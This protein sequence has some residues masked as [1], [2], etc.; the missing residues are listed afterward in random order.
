MLSAADYDAD[1]VIVGAGSAGCV[2]AERLS[3][4]GRHS[5]IVIEAGGSDRRFWINVPLG[6]GRL[7]YDRRVNWMYE[8]ATDPG[9][10]GRRDY[11][12]R[13]RVMGGSS[14]INAMVY[15]RGQQ[16]DY[17]GWAAEGNPGWGWDDVAPVFAD[18]EDHGG[19]HAGAPRVAI[20]DV[21]EHAHPLSRRV[22]E[23]GET[24][25]LPFNPDFNGA[26]QEGTG[27]YRLSRCARGRRMSAARAF[28]RP[29][30][31][32]ANVRVLSGVQVERV[33]F[34]GQRAT[35][36]IARDAGRAGR[37]GATVTIRAHRETVLAAGAIGSPHLLQLS[38]I[39]PGN[40]L[41]TLGVAPMVANENVGAHLQDHLGYSFFFRAH[42]ATLNQQLDTWPKRI[43]AGLHYLMR[44]RGPL[45]LSVNQSGGFFRT[46][47]SAVPNMQLYCQVLTTLSARHTERP[48]L[49]PDPF[50]AFSLGI[51]SCRPK[52]R[53]TVQAVSDD[54]RI[55]PAIQPN[56]F[57]HPDDM[58]EM[59]EGAQYV[60]RLSETPALHD[61][62]ESEVAPGAACTTDAD[63]EADIRRRAGTTFHP[64]GT[65]RMAPDAADGVVDPRLRVHGVDGLRVVD[66]SVF[67]HI[68]SGNLNGPAMMTGAKG[69]AF[70][71]ADC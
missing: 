38:G 21:S 48:L 13:G 26:T 1:F 20:S 4:D 69:A 5:V 45:S 11:W 65:C 41:R 9:L 68:V 61:E 55:A 27:Y 34:D 51:S 59:I 16:R 63:F 2:L 43:R 36:V 23:A 32:R 64:C 56:S 47:S 44:R 62:I 67:P 57:S 70:I 8:T 3:R 29:A 15:I 18:L 30:M 58:R 14:S 40:L 6:Y 39:G 46:P 22:I 19:A 54:P 52:S 35:G 17:D 28:L 42:H 50:P 10:D 49:M 37:R 24:L 60:R 25:Q 7:F 33:M 66:A 12:P 71:L 31:R 53:G